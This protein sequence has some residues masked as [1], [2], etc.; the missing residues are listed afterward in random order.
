MIITTFTELE[1][2]AAQIQAYLEITMSDDLNEAKE[3]ATALS[4]YNA[5]LS[6]MYAD[7]KY[8]RYYGLKGLSEKYGVSVTT[9]SKIIN[10]KD[11]CWINV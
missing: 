7:A 3:R 10:K 8:N 9:I 11:T 5:R 2:E 6:K 4:V 1:S